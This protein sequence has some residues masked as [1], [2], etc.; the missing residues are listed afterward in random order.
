MKPVSTAAAV[1]AV[2]VLVIAAVVFELYSWRDCL[3][4]NSLLFCIRVLL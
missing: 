3:R 2:V 1:A 4:A